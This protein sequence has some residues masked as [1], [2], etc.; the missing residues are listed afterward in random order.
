MLPLLDVPYA[1]SNA[2]VYR[3]LV[4]RWWPWISYEG[5]P[6][7]SVRDIKRDPRVFPTTPSG[8]DVR[9]FAHQEWAEVPGD[10][11]RTL[12]DRCPLKK[13]CLLLIS[14]SESRTQAYKAR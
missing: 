12:D 9:L 6:I 13:A 1:P 2:R 4:L 14:D 8:R 10:V 3:L 11:T 7:S 5:T